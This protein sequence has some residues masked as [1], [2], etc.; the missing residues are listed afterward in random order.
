MWFDSDLEEGFF[1]KKGDQ[2]LLVFFFFVDGK[3]QWLHE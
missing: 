2:C 3:S 1:N